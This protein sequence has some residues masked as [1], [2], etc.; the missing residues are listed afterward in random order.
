[1]KKTQFIDAFRGI[2]KRFVS[3]LSIVIIVLIAAGSYYL[4]DFMSEGSKKTGNEYFDSLNYMDLQMISSLGISEEQIEKISKLDGVESAE[5]V[6]QLNGRIA[7]P[8]NAVNVTIMT[9]TKKINIPEVLEGRLPE[10]ENECAV[11]ADLAKKYG[12]ETGEKV[13][14][15]ALFQDESALKNEEVKITGLYNHPNYVRNNSSVYSVLIDASAI[16]QEVLNDLYTRVII[17]QKGND[18]DTFSNIYFNAQETLKKDLIS[19]GFEL[20]QSSIDYVK[21]IF[22]DKINRFKEEVYAKIADAQQQIDEAKQKAEKELASAWAKI[23]E[24]QKLLESSYNELVA[25]ES[26]VDCRESELKQAIY[27]YNKTKEK[28]EALKLDV[29]KL[30]ERVRKI[31][32]VLKGLKDLMAQEE[33]HQVFSKDRADALVAKLEEYIETLSDALNDKIIDSLNQ[34]YEGSGDLAEDFIREKIADARA[35]ID[36]IIEN[37]VDGVVDGTNKRYRT[38]FDKVDSGNKT[39]I[40]LLEQAIDYIKKFLGAEAEIAAGQQK[41][42]DARWLISDGWLKYEDGKKQLDN[43]I[44]LYNQKKAEV[45]KQ[46][47]DAQNELDSQKADAERQLSD[48]EKELDDL[49]CHWVVTDRRAETGYNDIY[50]N[51]LSVSNAGKIFGILFAIVGGLVCFS[52]LIIIIEEER[53]LV[54]T[55]KA[56]GFRN[57]EIL[58]KYLMFGVLSTLLGCLIAVVIGIY[59]AR[60]MQVVVDRIGLFNTG[61]A[62]VVVDWKKIIFVTLAAV[63]ASTIVT[64]SACTGLLRAPASALM[65]GQTSLDQKPRKKKASVNQKGSLY[66]RLIIRNMINDK[67]RVIISII[68]VAGSVLVIG[69]GFCVRDSFKI[70]LD[71]QTDLVD[72]YTFRLDLGS[73]VSDDQKDQIKAVLDEGGA[74]YLEAAFKSTLYLHGDNLEGINIL[75]TDDRIEDYITIAE[76]KTRKKLLLPEEG[77]LIQN[78]MV[79]NDSLTI[80]DQ[81]TVYDDKLDEYTVVYAGQYDNYIGRQIIMSQNAYEKAFGKKAENNCY[82]VDLNG[83]DIEPIKDKISNITYDVSYYMADSM[84]VKFSSILSLYNIIVVL[85]LGF[86]IIM[87]FMIL[88]NLA[89]I[90]VTRKRKELI[91]MRINGYSISKT[92]QYLMRE[93]IITT[94]T[95]IVLGVGFGSYLITRIIKIMEQPDTQFARTFNPK[96]WILAILI[97]SLFAFIVYTASFKKIEKLNF[98]EVA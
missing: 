67:A 12:F 47:E 22:L 91:V 84:A 29:E 54:G 38:L 71:N 95:G 10:N 26:E 18:H 45:L 92:K 25:S 19:L 52:T 81:Y 36:H 53:K 85:M 40:E 65:K 20:E 61:V 86:A 49:S 4:T 74:R 41:I 5:G 7:D 94:L 3:F 28:V 93:T 23:K 39:M 14:L 42:A 72:R 21:Q 73:N 75:V 79:E 43:G 87:S 35:L 64:V 63:A 50:S 27:A 46:L 17:M 31:H 77:A 88:T 98:R 89:N 58:S 44:R 82:Y 6:V 34:F 59:G 55:S 56:F 15:S 68:I 76:P 11:A 37:T 80:G 2:R 1:M 8:E 60:F 57:N 24:N 13:M 96:A 66:S 62:D 78:R 33:Y 51:I 69:T 16:D 83:G 32:S 90:F 70:M 97:E 30:F 9:V 48:K